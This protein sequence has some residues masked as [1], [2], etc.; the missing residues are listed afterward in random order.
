MVPW[1]GPPTSYVNPWLVDVPI[2]T[3][4]HKLRWA[5]FPSFET[6]YVARCERAADA[7]ANP[8]K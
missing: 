3:G 1:G 7:F 6:K 2:D 5:K 4:D 8:P